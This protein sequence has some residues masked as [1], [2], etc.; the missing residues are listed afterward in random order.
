[1]STFTYFMFAWDKQAAQ[2]G[3]WRTAENTLYTLSLAR[4][5]PGALLAQVTR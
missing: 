3:S 4:G 1:M 2:N 5:W